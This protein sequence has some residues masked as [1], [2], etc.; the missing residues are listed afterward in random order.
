MPASVHQHRLSLAQSDIQALVE[1]LPHFA[2]ERFLYRL[3]V[4]EHAERSVLRG[5]L[6][7]QTWRSPEIPTTM[8]VDLLGQIPNEQ[9]AIVS[10]IRGILRAK[11]RPDGSAFDPASIRSLRLTESAEFNGTPARLRGT[12]GTA[13]V[14]MHLDV[15][16]GDAVNP[17]PAPAVLRALLEFPA[18]RMLLYRREST[19]TEK[20]EA[21]S[22]NARP[23]IGWT[24]SSRPM[25]PVTVTSRERASAAFVKVQAR[26]HEFAGSSDQRPIGSRDCP[27]RCGAS[28]QSQLPQPVRQAQPTWPG[29]RQRSSTLYRPPNISGPHHCW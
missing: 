25:P 1:I 10:P 2:A 14:H 4:S 13:Q 8:D 15:A 27:E 6:M 7:L 5:A 28:C 17:E 21:P 9:E 22:A 3:S 16:F 29:P 26:G 20:F 11:A 19:V 18:P 12:L 23:T 24:C